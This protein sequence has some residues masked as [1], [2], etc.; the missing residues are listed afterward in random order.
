[1]NW[2]SVGDL[3]TFLAL[4]SITPYL[5]NVCLFPPKLTPCLYS[6]AL[7]LILKLMYKFNQAKIQPHIIEFATFCLYQLVSNSNVLT[8][9]LAP[10]QAFVP[11]YSAFSGALLKC[12]KRYMRLCKRS[13]VPKY[14]KIMDMSTCKLSTCCHCHCHCSAP[15]QHE[16]RSVDAERF[17]GA[18]ESLWW[19][20]AC[21]GGARR[22]IRQLC[23]P[24]SAVLRIRFLHCTHLPFQQRFLPFS[25]SHIPL[26]IPYSLLP[27]HL[28]TTLTKWEDGEDDSDLSTPSSYLL[29]LFNT[30]PFVNF[31]LEHHF[32]TKPI[33]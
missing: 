27:L 17:G 31:V 14:A 19:Q 12:I 6:H 10:F 9:K 24:P 25:F 15:D 23:T 28:F 26:L 32:F 20:S 33:L 5:S 13:S 1:M 7:L 11:F 4:N 2:Q 8:V 22:P 30:H 29:F 16:A 18:Q 3:A 21:E